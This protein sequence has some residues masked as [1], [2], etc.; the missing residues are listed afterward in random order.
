MAGTEHILGVLLLSKGT[1]SCTSCSSGGVM[2]TSG[3][4]EEV[5]FLYEMNRIGLQVTCC[6]PDCDLC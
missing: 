1:V 5:D 2:M 6:H 4:S 3:Y